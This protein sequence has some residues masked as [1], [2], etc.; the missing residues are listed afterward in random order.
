M[1]YFAD[2]LR[3]RSIIW[4]LS[5]VVAAAGLLVACGTGQ[6]GLVQ[7]ASVR[8]QV[9]QATEV[10]WRLVRNVEIGIA[11][12]FTTY[13]E[14][15]RDGRLSFAEFGRVV[16]RDWFDTRDANGDGYV[17]LDEWLT[18]AE[19]DRQIAE[20]RGRASSLVARADRNG[21]RRLS[22]E[23]FLGYEAFIVEPTPWLFEPADPRIKET[24]FQ[25]HAPEGGQLDAERT[26][27]LVGDLLEQGYWLEDAN[28]L[29]ASG[30]F[31]AK[32]RP[33]R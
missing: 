32:V 5:G 31:L 14:A 22:R 25:R 18:P 9:L 27:F 7:R 26:A 8:P 1:L 6:P 3:G 28:D 4:S 33:V 21:D 24:A 29:A 30:H 16:T 15:P 2:F 12:I 20:I 11:R 19:V 13:D 23:E 10:S 17:L